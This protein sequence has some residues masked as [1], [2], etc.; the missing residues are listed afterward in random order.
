[1]M[2]L[3]LASASP[4]RA[5]LLRQIELSFSVE[6]SP[7]PEPLPDGRAPEV[8]AVYSAQC[9][10]R[11]VLR[12]LQD[13][14]AATKALII[15]ADTVVCIDGVI[16]GKPADPARPLRCWLG[17][18]GGNTGSAGTERGLRAARIEWL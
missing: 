15:G 5:E 16:L 12:L 8:F 9:K 17:F 1:M 3:V 6:P 13:R 14:G 11:S 10:A 18:P 4:R 7:D 2:D